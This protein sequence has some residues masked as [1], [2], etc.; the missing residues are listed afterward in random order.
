MVIEFTRPGKR[1]HNELENHH[2][3]HGKIHYFD[4]AMASIAILTQP[5][6]TLNQNFT[7]H[8][9]L[10][11]AWTTMDDHGWTRWKASHLDLPAKPTG[12]PLQVGDFSPRFGSPRSRL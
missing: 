5:E 8:P 2:A 9:N 12:F 4:W 11:Q 6:G 7:H 1:L 10:S 3:I